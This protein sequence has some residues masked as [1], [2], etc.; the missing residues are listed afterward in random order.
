[1]K[2]LF[3][4]TGKV[5]LVSGGS[6]G[7]GFQFAK[8]LAGQGADIALVARRADR[9]EE[10]KKTIEAMGVKCYTHFIDFLDYPSIAKCVE[11]VVAHYG[12]IDILMNAAGVRGVGSGAE[13]SNEEWLGVI[14]ADL[15]GQYF[16]TR[17]VARLAMIPRKY[18]K[19]INILSI[20]AFVG[21][22]GIAT[23]SYC[24]AKGG[25][26]TLTKALGNE[27]A[28][29]NIT[30]NAI[31]PGYFPTEITAA[32]I[33]TE[34]FKKTCETYCPF[35]RPGRTGEMDGIA[36]YFA[37]DASSYTTGQVVSVDGGWLTV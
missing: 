31:A 24:A 33:D 11:N 15:N 32:Y 25:M 37:S 13:Q 18:G 27:W 4:L 23:G 5:A 2:N 10:N 6:S 28:K 19:V 22:I 29:H 16:L 34:A 14:D 21:R 8:V 30:V 36:I 35:G 12:R 7:L 1:M 17:D 20:H 9:L 3:D 26:L